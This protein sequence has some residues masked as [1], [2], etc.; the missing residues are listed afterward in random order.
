MT[1]VEFVIFICGDHFDELHQFSVKLVFLVAGDF[2]DERLFFHEIWGYVDRISGIFGEQIGIVDFIFINLD[3]G[4]FSLLMTSLQFIQFIL[5][6]DLGKG[7][8]VSDN[9][10]G[11]EDGADLEWDRL[12]QSIVIRGI[13][14]VDI[15]LGN[16][17]FFHLIVQ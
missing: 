16:W 1:S 3:Q 4:S 14:R 9:I 11:F 6:S 7:L 2:G 5:D 15:L 12:S 8:F 10:R 17:K 13:N